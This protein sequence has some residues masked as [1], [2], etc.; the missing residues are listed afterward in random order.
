M[1]GERRAKPLEVTRAQSDRSAPSYAAGRVRKTDEAFA[2]VGLEQLDQRS[3]TLVA[4][5][6]RKRD[7]LDRVGRPPR[8]R[9]CLRT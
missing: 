1:L 5:A 3:E 8:S 2:L 9:D 7:V 4:G 6:L